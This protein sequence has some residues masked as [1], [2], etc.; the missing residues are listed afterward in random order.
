LAITPL[1]CY[2][3]STFRNSSVFSKL[4]EQGSVLGQIV[5]RI[6]SKNVLEMDARMHV[7]RSASLP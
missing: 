3:F 6:V 5:S 7:P 1:F 4:A 2:V